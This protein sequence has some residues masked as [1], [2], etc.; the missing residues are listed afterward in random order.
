MKV[1]VEYIRYTQIAKAQSMLI[2]DAFWMYHTGHSDRLTRIFSPVKPILGCI[3][4]GGRGKDGTIRILKIGVRLNWLRKELDYSVKASKVKWNQSLIRSD[5]SEVF[6]GL[7]FIQVIQ[8]Y[9]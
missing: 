1:H 8:V 6:T 5:M 9:A 7:V 4:W 3:S 2:D